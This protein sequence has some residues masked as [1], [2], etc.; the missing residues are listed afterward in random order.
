[1]RAALSIGIGKFNGHR[2]CCFLPANSSRLSQSRRLRIAITDI[3][4]ATKAF[5]DFGIGR[6]WLKRYFC[7]DTDTNKL[8]MDHR[9]YALLACNLEV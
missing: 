1:M 7:L 3:Y 4:R 6:E 8:S 2:I 9:R 5:F